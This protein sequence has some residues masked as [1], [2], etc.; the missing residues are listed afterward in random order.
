MLNRRL[1]LQ[2]R[3]AF[4]LVL[5][6]VTCQAVMAQNGDNGVASRGSAHQAED[7]TSVSLAS[8]HLTPLAPAVGE[9]DKLPGFTRELIRV[10]W[11][12]GDPIYLYV[13]LPRNAKKPPAILYLYSYPSESDRF[14][15]NEFCKFLSKNGV[16]AVGF[17][18]ALTGQRYHDRPMRQWFVSE[19]QE[20]LVS[21]AHDVQMILNYL[22][23]RGDIDIDHIGMFGSGSGAAIAVLAAGVDKRIKAIELVDPWGD[24]PHWVAKSPVIPENERANYVKSEFLKKVAPFDPVQWLP[25]LKIPV[26]LQY[27]IPESATPKEAQKSI[28]A[29][30]PPQAQVITQKEGL[31]KYRATLGQNFFDW[32][33]DQVRTPSKV[34][35]PGESHGGKEKSAQF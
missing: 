14:L 1:L 3:I 29:A 10:Q 12:N 17:V 26:R 20:S 16:A 2:T 4:M 30:A 18:S 15:D 24:W 31:A 7:L 25:R 19:L 13:I 27:L 28:L 22:S 5:V 35:A 8:S 23:T 6:L 9:T 34:Q 33:I 32:L 21:S 11:R